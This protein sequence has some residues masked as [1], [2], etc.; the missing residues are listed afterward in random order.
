MTMQRFKERPTGTRR[1]ALDTQKD[2]A[3]RSHLNVDLMDGG[4]QS[5]RKAQPLQ[6]YV[7]GNSKGG[8]RPKRRMRDDKAPEKA[9]ASVRGLECHDPVARLITQT[10]ATRTPT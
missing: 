5:W 2:S 10:P 3:R 7:E 1:G 6:S 4:G 9:C 8:W